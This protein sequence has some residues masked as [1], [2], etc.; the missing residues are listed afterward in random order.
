MKVLIVDDDAIQRMLMADL[1]SRFEKIEVVEAADGNSAWEELQN[2][3]CPVLC[4]CDMRMPGM[5]GMELLQRFK[6]RPA[7]AD[8]PFVF[9]TASTD[10]NTIQEAIAAG[11]TN[12]ILKP[13]NIAK[14]RSSLE[15]VFRGIRDRYSEEPTATQKR[16]RAPPDKLLSYF[17]A[18]KLQLADAQLPVHE[19]LINGEL[20]P[21]RATLDSLKTGCIALGLWHAATMI[22]YVHALEP[23]LVDR[24]LKDVVTI[25]D[26]QTRRIKTE[27]GIRG[28]PQVAVGDVAAK[29]GMQGD[30]QGG[31]QVAA[32]A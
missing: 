6:S 17:D 31:E 4:C 3:L 32:V 25:V 29:R 26:E 16:L 21:A 15:K 8:V 5:T 18:L 7:L 19:H 9:I 28:D 14:A 27:F 13:F 23:D 2:G 12:Y 11:A 24:I 10:R 20:E 22:E 1:L 30:A